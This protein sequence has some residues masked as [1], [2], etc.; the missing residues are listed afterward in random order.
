MDTALAGWGRVSPDTCS[1]NCSWRASFLASLSAD[2]TPAAISLGAYFFALPG[3]ICASVT[4]H[5][6]WWP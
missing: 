6:T 4:S 3:A 5:V 2:A 1:R